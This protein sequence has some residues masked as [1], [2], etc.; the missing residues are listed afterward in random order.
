MT[1]AFYHGAKA[2]NQTKSSNWIK[3]AITSEWSKSYD[4]TML[5]SF[6]SIKSSKISLHA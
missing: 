2:L 6:E 4:S 5:N 3:Q 1:S